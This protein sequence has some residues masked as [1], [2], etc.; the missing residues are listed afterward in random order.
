MTSREQVQTQ[1]ALRESVK[2]QLEELL[3][4]YISLEG[5]PRAQTHRSGLAIAAME[6]LCG[7][8]RQQK[9]FVKQ[10]IAS[11]PAPKIPKEWSIGRVTARWNGFC[12]VC[13]KAGITGQLVAWDPKSGKPSTWQH[14]SCVDRWGENGK[15]K[16]GKSKNGRMF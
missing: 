3:D 4:K 11:A 10:Q 5:A 9:E 12:R 13:N 14:V 1:R 15:S 6:L 2:R 16:S 7:Y 8:R